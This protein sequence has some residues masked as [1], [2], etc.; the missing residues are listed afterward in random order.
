MVEKVIR[1][2]V[3]HAML[4][5]AK[6]NNKYMKAYDEGEER[7]SFLQCNDANTLYGFATSELLPVD[8]FEWMKDLSKIDEDFIKN[9]D[10]NSDKGH[11]LEVNVE[12][13]KNLHDLHNDLPFLPER[14]KIDKFKNLVCNLYDENSY[15][16]HITSLKQALN[17][18]LILKKVRRVIQF[19]QKAWL[20]PYI[21]M[22]TQLRKQA[23]KLF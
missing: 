21:D 7:E 8:G 15:V 5:Y 22:N 18:G 12:Y 2:G 20:K 3:C 11:I 17:H 6:A 4:R 14:M 23:K 13:P 19:N 1:G 9:Y 16:V 10:E